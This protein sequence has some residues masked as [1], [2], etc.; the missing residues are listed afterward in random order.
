[1]KMGLNKILFII[2]SLNIFT[3]YFFLKLS[4]TKKQILLKIKKRKER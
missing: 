3:N 1:L 2:I 4:F